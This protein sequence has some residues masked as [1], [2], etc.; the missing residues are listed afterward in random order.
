MSLNKARFT[1][2]RAD[3]SVDDIADRPGSAQESARRK[4]GS[5][6]TV[7]S[8]GS[9]HAVYTPLRNSRQVHLIDSMEI[10]IDG[11][12]VLIAACKQ[13]DCRHC[14]DRD[15]HAPDQNSNP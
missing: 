12:A 6:R 8:P 3:R 4:F 2:L 10:D 7:D 9:A 14:G 13:L 15:V 11:H 1:H 5:G